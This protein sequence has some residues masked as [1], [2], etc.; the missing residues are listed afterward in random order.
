MH[1]PQMLLGAII[2]ARGNFVADE[3]SLFAVN[4]D[5]VNTGLKTL[6]WQGC[7]EQGCDFYCLF[8]I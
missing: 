1:L 7:S 2:K 4:D 8:E 5:N 6:R 3:W